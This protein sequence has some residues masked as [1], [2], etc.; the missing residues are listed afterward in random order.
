MDISHLRHPWKACNGAG[1]L[2]ETGVPF[3]KE[4]HSSLGTAVTCQQTADLLQAPL[5]P[6]LGDIHWHWSPPILACIKIAE[7]FLTLPFPLKV[8]PFTF[9][10][11]EASP[12]PTLICFVSLSDLLSQVDGRDIFKI[13]GRNSH[14]WKPRNWQNRVKR[15]LHQVAREKHSFLLIEHERNRCTALFKHRWHF[16]G[17]FFEDSN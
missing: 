2:Q 3:Q 7:L 4:P 14:A 10:I 6:L 9:V 1:L 17:K 15:E 16:F 8:I 12:S 13:P 11:Y 5:L